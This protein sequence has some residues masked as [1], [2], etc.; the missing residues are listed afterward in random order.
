MNRAQLRSWLGQQLRRDTVPD[1]VWEFL[2][3]EAY[4]AAALEGDVTDQKHLVRAARRLLKMHGAVERIPDRPSRELTLQE[5]GQRTGARAVAL[6]EYLAHLAAE[7]PR[8]RQF[9]SMVLDG[10]VMSPAEARRWLASPAVAYLSRAQLQEWGIPIVSHCVTE[11]GLDSPSDSELTD[12]WR[13][14]SEVM[15]GGA[16]TALRDEHATMYTQQVVLREEVAGTTFTAVRRFKLL[17]R[18]ETVA[19]PGE[20]FTAIARTAVWPG[21]VLDE[22]RELSGRLAEHNRWQ[23]AQ[24]TWFILTGAIPVQGPVRVTQHTS[25][26]ASGPDEQVVTVTAAAWVPVEVVA[27]AYRVAQRELLG[28]ANRPLSER[29]LSLFRFVV[30]RMDTPGRRP[31]WEALRLAWNREHPQWQSSERRRFAKDF[32]RVL[33]AL[34]FPGRK[35]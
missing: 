31:S 2:N 15:V 4:V 9:R 29:N 12:D 23:E 33:Y 21:S 17:T 3:E 28:G 22:L 18:R 35:E 20:D 1:D 13:R 7:T 14:M 19:F 16:T 11:V 10:D 32:N 34:V 6:S 27:R 8:V 24:A 26:R 30:S 25:S 5:L